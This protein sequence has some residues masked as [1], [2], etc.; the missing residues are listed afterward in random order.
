MSTFKP[1]G[2]D[3]GWHYTGKC[4]DRSAN[5]KLSEHYPENSYPLSFLFCTDIPFAE[6]DIQHSRSRYITASPFSWTTDDRYAGNIVKNPSFENWSD[7]ASQAAPTYWTKDATM[8]NISRSTTHKTDSYSLLLTFD[9]NLAGTANNVYQ[10]V[11]LEMG[12]TYKIATWMKIANL[13]RGIIVLDL[14]LDSILAQ[15]VYLSANCD[16]TLLSFESTMSYQP[17]TAAISV[18]G[19]DPTGVNAGAQ[20]YV[21]SVLVT[22]ITNYENPT[23]ENA[24][25]TTGTVAAT[26][27]IE[28]ASQHHW[29]PLIHWDL[30]NTTY[31]GNST[32]YGAAKVTITTSALPAYMFRIDQLLYSIK[33]NGGTG[34]IKFTIQSASINLGS[35]A[36][37]EYT[38]WE[39][40]T[41]STD[42]ANGLTGSPLPVTGG[43]NEPI[44]VRMYLKATSG[45]TVSV[46]HLI[47]Y[48]T[49]Y[50][51]PAFP[52]AVT[53]YNAADE[54]T[55]MSICNGL[56]P[57]ASIRINGDGTGTYK[58][59]DEFTTMN[60][61]S[62]MY[63]LTGSIIYDRYLKYITLWPSTQFDIRFE[64]KWPIVGVPV[65]KML[66][67]GGPI[68]WIAEDIDGVPGTWYVCD[69][70]LTNQ[71]E[72]IFEQKPLDNDA[73]LSLAGR[74]SFFLRI[75]TYAA[76]VGIVYMELNC[77]LETIDAER[78]VILPGVTNT[79]VSEIQGDV[80]CYINLYYHDRKWG[81]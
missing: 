41:T 79:F 8:V 58:F 54:F 25:T 17:A 31:T 13:T 81:S 71:V 14:F 32:S 69:S 12:K 78:P 55:K 77:D 36:N 76:S 35:G 29:Y 3:V 57:G 5:L 9:G 21:D 72:N 67:G 42:Y 10:Y 30:Y 60:Y 33:T 65:L 49:Q 61:G 27:D 39:T 43:V 51:Q 28:I 20:C 74:T 18:H 64:M 7:G 68:T 47:Q 70:Q 2:I 15:S 48:D 73:N 50:P 24:I 4:G 52:T 6:S 75:E 80:F 34:Y 19:W 46:T 59:V 38:I 16:W 44:Y 23:F 1:G 37:V 63:H 40:S 56:Y 53:V 66:H 62:Y 22:D 11:P 26:P 45:N